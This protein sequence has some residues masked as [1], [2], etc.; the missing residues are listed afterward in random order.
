MIA[1]TGA[2]IAVVTASCQPAPSTTS[3]RHAATEPSPNA[4]HGRKGAGIVRMRE[5]SFRTRTMAPRTT[6]ERASHWWSRAMLM[7]S[8]GSMMS[9]CLL[10][11]R[12]KGRRVGW[13]WL[14]GADLLD[15]Q[16]VGE[17]DGD[18]RRD[19]VLRPKLGTEVPHLEYALSRHEEL[20]PRRVDVPRSAQ[21]RDDAATAP[22]RAK[23]QVDRRHGICAADRAAHHQP[24]ARDPVQTRSRET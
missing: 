24:D 15:D 4:S 9:P 2:T 6:A 17:R 22:D 13:S 23:Y 20:V 8:E 1:S 3:W 7:R 21:S 14:R 12:A 10:S 16:R 19:C 18:V 11:T 5:S